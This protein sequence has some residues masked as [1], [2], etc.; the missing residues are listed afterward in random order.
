MADKRVNNGRS[1]KEMLEIAE[2]GRQK[3]KTHQETRQEM[4]LEALQERF[5]VTQAAKAIGIHPI[6]A[7][8]W[9]REDEEFA[10]RVKEVREQAVDYA[11]T[12]LLENI[13]DGN[14]AS[15][16]FF[17]KTQGRHRGYIE[18]VALEINNERPIFNGIDFNL[19]EDIDAVSENNSTA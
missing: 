13:K 4:F 5:V 8:R 14:V 19:T 6:T 2:R 1:R 3:Q 18:N 9:I 10:E 7:Y 16:I 11:E 12:K 17:L 15:I